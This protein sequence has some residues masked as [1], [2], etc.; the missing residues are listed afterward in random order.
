MECYTVCGMLLSGISLLALQSSPGEGAGQRC[1]PFTTRKVELSENEHL[2][3]R[4]SVEL[5]VEELGWR[6]LLGVCSSHC[7][8]HIM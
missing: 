1:H 5:L 6:V 2:A 8:G 4:K 7:V 3:G